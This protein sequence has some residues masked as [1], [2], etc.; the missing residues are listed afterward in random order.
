VLAAIPETLLVLLLQLIQLPMAISYDEVG[1]ATNVAIEL[2]Q[3]AIEK[4]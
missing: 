1:A 2:A 4:V 3:G